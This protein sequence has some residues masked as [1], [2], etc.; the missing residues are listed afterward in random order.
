MVAKLKKN[1]LMHAS[2]GRPIGAL[3]LANKTKER[4]Y[5][6]SQRIRLLRFLLTP[7]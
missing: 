2:I 4:R 3:V 1:E 5:V 6:R 7:K